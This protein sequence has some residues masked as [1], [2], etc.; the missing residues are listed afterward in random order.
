MSLFLDDYIIPRAR[1][2]LVTGIEDLSAFQYL[3]SSPTGEEIADFQTQA[4]SALEQ[5]HKHGL[6]VAGGWGVGADLIGWVA[7]F[8]NIIYAT[9]DQPEYVRELLEM[10]GRWNRKRMEVVLDAGVDLFIKRAWYE[11]CD[12][13]TPATW[14]NFLLPELEADVDLAHQAGAKF[15]YIITSNAMPLLEMIA[16]AG[17]DVVI[18]VDPQEWN[19]EQ[20]R[21]Q[22]GGE[23]CLWGGVN[24]HLT[25]EMG[26]PDDV[27]LEVEQAMK[28]LAPGGGFI[29]SPV[30]NVRQDTPT[31]QRNTD[32]LIDM[33][34][35]LRGKL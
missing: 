12:F 10:I 32:I 15:G 33:W 5:A 24:G 23:C 8:E 2:L 26:S 9:F 22:L 1:K 14:K 34:K 25:V 35:R 7:G 4:K 20:T 16:G 28:I 6:A 13:W 29:L 17:V 27:E 11:N 21:Q 18:G 30:D 19:L 3:L 31:A